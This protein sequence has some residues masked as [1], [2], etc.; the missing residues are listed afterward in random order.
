MESALIEFKDVSSPEFCDLILFHDYMSEGKYAVGNA[1][2]DNLGP[3]FNSMF[4]RTP[5]LKTRKNYSA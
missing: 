4:H 5:R 1:V 2:Q 3:V